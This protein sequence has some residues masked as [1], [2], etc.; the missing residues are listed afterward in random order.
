MNTVARTTPSNG[1]SDTYMAG[2]RAGLEDYP[3]LADTVHQRF[4]A[5][6]VDLAEMARGHLVLD[7]LTADD[8][9]AV[10]VFL[11]RLG[12]LSE[13]QC[14]ELAEVIFAEQQAHDA[15]ARF[16]LLPGGAA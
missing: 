16:Q 10:I 7:Q 5:P 2:Y 14:E 11:D 12:T 3:R 8:R 13:R 4:G 15:R 9:K 6:S 1:E